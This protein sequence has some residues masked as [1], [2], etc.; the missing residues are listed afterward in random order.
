MT[1]ANRQVCSEIVGAGLSRGVQFPHLMLPCPRE[2]EGSVR[3]S[4]AKCASSLEVCRHAGGALGGGWS[5][6]D[7]TLSG[8][9]LPGPRSRGADGSFNQY[10]EMTDLEDGLAADR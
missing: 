7:P 4:D 8:P 2:Q 9:A 6:P 10:G 3:V 5:H 1:I